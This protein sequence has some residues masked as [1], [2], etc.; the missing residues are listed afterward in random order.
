MES[1]QLSRYANRL[2]AGRQGFDS[3]QGQDFMPFTAS[4]S[5]LGPLSYLSYGYRGLFPMERGGRNVKL[6]THLRDQQRWSYILLRVSS[7]HTAKLNKHR[8]N[9]GAR[10]SVVVEAL[11]YSVFDSRWGQRNFSIRLTLSAALGPGVYSASNRNECHK[12]KKKKKGRR[13]RLTF[14][15][16]SVSRLSRQCEVLNISQPYRPARTVTGIPL[17]VTY[18]IGIALPINFTPWGETQETSPKCW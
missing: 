14:S 13:I 1:G 10:G 3:W 12:Q 7:W 11:Y 5:A 18:F 8:D 4:R 9:F 17:L 15:P 6:T 2:R 16:P